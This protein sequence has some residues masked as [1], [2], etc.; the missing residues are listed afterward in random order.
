MLEHHVANNMWAYFVVEH[1]RDKEDLTRDLAEA[2]ATSGFRP[3]VAL[4]GG[5][6]AAPLRRTCGEAR[7]H[8]RF[9]V[10]GSLDQAF[11]APAVIKHVLNDNS[12][13]ASTMVMAGR[14][15]DWEAFFAAVPGA[16]TVWTLDSQIQ[17]RRSNYNN[18]AVSTMINPI[19]P[20]QYFAGGA[21]AAEAGGERARVQAE[22][23]AAQAAVGRAQ[24]AAAA[25]QPRLADVQARKKEVQREMAALT[26]TLAAPLTQ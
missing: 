6:P 15:H 22:L 24:Q 10:T 26:N 25:L 23:E 7:A 21:G 13:V 1:Q 12:F 16:Q 5:D 14:D 19:R 18:Q 3:M 20:A 17:Q 9:G 4:Y 2:C 8:A 11:T